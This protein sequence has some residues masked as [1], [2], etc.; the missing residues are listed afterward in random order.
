MLMVGAAADSYTDEML[1]VWW[2]T[3]CKAHSK[4]VELELEL[5]VQ[6]KWWWL[7]L[8]LYGDG[9]M[10]HIYIYDTLYIMIEIVL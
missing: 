7:V 5:E 3:Q 2:H 10:I 1:I 8:M 9:S 4:A 6:V